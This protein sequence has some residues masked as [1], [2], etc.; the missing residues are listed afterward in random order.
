MLQDQSVTQAGVKAPGNDNVV[1][2][3][4]RKDRKETKFD[5]Q[6]VSE[7]NRK[8]VQSIVLKIKKNLATQLFNAVEIGGDLL[9][10]K[11]LVGHGNF[12]TLAEARI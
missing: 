12:P 11:E 7:E 3:T 9:R 2:I 10:L 8:E 4:S 5:Y 6:V 1:A